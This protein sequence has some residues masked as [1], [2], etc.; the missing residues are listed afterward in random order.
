VNRALDRGLLIN[1]T[2]DRVI[3]LLPPLIIDEAHT[4]EIAR[5]LIDCINDF[6]E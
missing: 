5:I 2:A 1:V 3:R 6:T 4:N